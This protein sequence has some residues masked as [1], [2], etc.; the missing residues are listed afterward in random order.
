MRS[1][2]LRGFPWLQIE[3]GGCGFGII[4]LTY[5]AKPILYVIDCRGLRNFVLCNSFDINE[6]TKGGWGG[7]REWY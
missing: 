6:L 2:Q 4:C 3:A 7:V 5:G 1:Q